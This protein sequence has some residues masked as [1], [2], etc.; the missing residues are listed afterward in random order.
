MK[1]IYAISALQSP[2]SF[3]SFH[4]PLSTFHDIFYFQG[5]VN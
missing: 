3:L 2:L 5:M 4:V 1:E